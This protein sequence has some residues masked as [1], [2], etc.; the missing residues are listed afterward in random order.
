[1]GFGKAFQE[2]KML[3]VW[4]KVDLLREEEPEGICISCLTGKGLPQLAQ[5]IEDKLSKIRGQSTRM[6]E[7]GIEHH[8]DVMEWIKKN[9]SHS[10]NIES[11]YNYTPSKEHPHGSVKIYL[12]LDDT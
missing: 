1:M 9:T 4:N 3:E 2:E 7:Y 12:N 11:D 6:V 5:Q 8:G 10:Y